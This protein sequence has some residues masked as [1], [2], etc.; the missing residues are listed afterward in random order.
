MAT[1]LE[2]QPSPVAEAPLEPDLPICDPHHHLRERPNDR[3][4]LEEFFKIPAPGTISWRRLRGKSR[5]V[6]HGWSRD[7][8][9][10]RRDRVLR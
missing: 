8:E 1:A 6:S 7:N 4:F 2:N 9:A 5:D 10:H 3:Y